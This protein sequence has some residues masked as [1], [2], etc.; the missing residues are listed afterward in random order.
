MG[1]RPPLCAPETARSDCVLDTSGTDHGHPKDAVLLSQLV[2]WTRHGRDVVSAK[3]GFTRRANSGSRKRGYRAK[4]KKTRVDGYAAST[5]RRNGGEVVRRACIFGFKR[6]RFRLRCLTTSARKASASVTRLH[7]R[8]RTRN[9][10]VVW[11]KCR[12]SSGAGRGDRE[13]QRG[14]DAFA[15]DPVA[16]PHARFKWAV[17]QSHGQSMGAGLRAKT[18]AVRERKAQTAPAWVD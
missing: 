3:A 16:T 13:C 7:A 14:T 18:P 6:A 5:S 12:V 15:H 4:S 1:F 8:Q 9:A 2:Y 11:S 10:R 17:V